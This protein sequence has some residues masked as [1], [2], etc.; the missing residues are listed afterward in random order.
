MLKSTIYASA[1]ALAICS[2]LKAGN[3]E[4]LDGEELGKIQT[5]QLTDTVAISRE[6][7]ETYS[8]EPAQIINSLVIDGHEVLIVER[9]GAH[10]ALVDDEI[11]SRL[12]FRRIDEMPKHES[13]SWCESSCIDDAIGKG[14]SG[15]LDGMG[16]G[17]V[18]GAAIGAGV[19]GYIGGAPGAGIGGFIGGGVGAVGGAAAGAAAGGIEGYNTCEKEKHEKCA[20]P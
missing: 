3:P 8:V 15:G 2:D 7:F 20:Q 17:A 16:K 11:L 12:Y 9:D 6:D 19:G 13:S 18:G 10:A 1:L 5:I 4:F 14:L